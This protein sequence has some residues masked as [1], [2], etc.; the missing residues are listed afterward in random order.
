M[1]PTP[2]TMLTTTLDRM[3]AGGMYDQL[4]GGFAR[5]STDAAWL[6]PALR[7]DALRQRAARA[8]VYAR[9]V[10]HPRRAL[11]ADRDRDPRVPAPRDA[12]SGRRILLEP[13]RRLRGRRG[14]VLHLVV[15]R[16]HGL[17]GE[18]AAERLRGLSRRQLGRESMERGRTSCGDRTVPSSRQ[19]TSRRPDGSCSRNGKR[20]VR[21]ATDDKVLTAWNAMA[22]QAFAEAGRAFGN[23]R[24][25]LA[26]VDAAEFVLSNLRSR[27]R[28]APPLLAR[29]RTRAVRR[30]RTTM[31]CS[32]PR[33]LALFSRTGELRWFLEAKR[34][35]DDLVR[36]FADHERG[37]FFQS[38]AD[39]DALVIRPKE[40]YDN[41]VPSGNSA[42]A[43]VIQRIALL[44]GDLELERIGVSADPAGP[45]RPRKS[46]DGLRTCAL[47]ARSLPGADP[48]GGDRRLDGR[49]RR[50]GP[51]GRGPRG[52][53]PP[54]H[55]RRDRG[56]R[57]RRRRPRRSRCSATAP[58][59]T[60]SRPP[61]C[62]SDSRAGSR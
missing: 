37:G 30:T 57:R 36:L 39:D 27:R 59:W 3:A 12:A 45:R 51:R 11:S 34:L 4:G 28:Q 61:S 5:Y 33:M 41:A 55:R 60:G 18:E 16:A 35:V 17:V 38:G 40:L 2:S 14:E 6:G 50:P 58:R 46:A 20:R 42:A 49:S 48:R 19:E 43:D 44:T 31:R 47:G 1:R 9:L 7:E 22:I 25:H 56:A 24:F 26:A 53:V 8:A 52:S 15:G 54:E 13:G 21:P 10:G 23:E 29:G 32:R 62:A